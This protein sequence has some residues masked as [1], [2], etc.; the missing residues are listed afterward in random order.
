MSDPKRPLLSGQFGRGQTPVAFVLQEAPSLEQNIESAPMI[1][2]QPEAPP[3]ADQ[4][5]GSVATGSR[6]NP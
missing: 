3:P 1:P 6:T 4:R 5:I 2:D